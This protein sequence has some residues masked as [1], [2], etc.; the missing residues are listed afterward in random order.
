VL[1][2]QLNSLHETRCKSNKPVGDWFADN[3]RHYA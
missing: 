2:N 3:S 1:K